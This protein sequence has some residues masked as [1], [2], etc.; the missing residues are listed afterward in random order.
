MCKIETLN[1]VIPEVFLDQRIWKHSNDMSYYFFFL[2]LL[3]WVTT[4]GGRGG[5]LLFFKKWP[6]SLTGKLLRL[7]QA[8]LQGGPAWVPLIPSL[9]SF[10]LLLKAGETALQTCMWQL[11][12]CCSVAKLCLTLCNPTDCSTPGFP[13]SQNVVPCNG[14]PRR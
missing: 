7:S 9:Y 8:L 4:I 3:H 5:A 1:Q 2:F 13:I 14:K 11:P 6:L 10:L 12:M